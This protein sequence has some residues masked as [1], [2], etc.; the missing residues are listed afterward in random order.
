MGF[1]GRALKLSGHQ[2][3]EGAVLNMLL[4]SLEAVRYA[5]SKESNN[6]GETLPVLTNNS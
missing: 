5:A 3:D 1:G 6:T 4:L 2:K